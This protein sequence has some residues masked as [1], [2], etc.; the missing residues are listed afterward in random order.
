M[1]SQ[2]KIGCMISFL[3]SS[4]KAGSRKYLGVIGSL[5]TK[6]I[7]QEPVI[8]HL[9]AGTSFRFFP[10]ESS[11]YSGAGKRMILTTFGHDAL[12]ILNT[13]KESSFEDLIELSV[14]A[15][16]SQQ[17]SKSLL[18]EAQKLAALR[19]P[20]ATL[21]FKIRADSRWSYIHCK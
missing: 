5:L 7:D 13:V 18:K 20:M 21:R 14:F 11:R 8:Q 1:I 9:L 6:I 4:R 16:N 19:W 3:K 12:L 17:S 10:S 2:F 15:N